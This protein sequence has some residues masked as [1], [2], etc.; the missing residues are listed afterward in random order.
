MFYLNPAPESENAQIR[1]RE[2][3]HDL[4][5]DAGLV[6]VRNIEIKK[7]G[8]STL[9]P[10]KGAEFCLTGTGLPEAGIT[11]TSDANGIVSFKNQIS[12][13]DGTVYRINYYG[14]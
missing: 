7:Y 4:T 10:L 14:N 2:G 13:A 3:G 12:E 1:T 8:G 5:Y 6:R 11:A 9:N